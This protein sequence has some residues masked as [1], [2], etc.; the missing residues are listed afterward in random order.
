MGRLVR[1][2]ALRILR[3]F[4]SPIEVANDRLAKAAPAAILVLNHPNGI[5]DPAVI[6]TVLGRPVAFLAKSTPFGYPLKCWFMRQFGALPI[7]RA[8][9]L[10]RRGG[11]SDRDDMHRRNEETF[12]KCRALLNGGNAVA[13][14]PEG[15]THDEPMMM[16]ARTGAARIALS[17]AESSNWSVPQIIPVGIWYENSTR[18]RST[19]LVVPGK[20]VEIAA[21]RNRF[22]EAPREAV[23]ELTALLE[24]GLRAVVLEAE[25]TELL[26]SAPFIAA[27]TQPEGHK[28]DLKARQARAAELLDGYR[29]MHK[30]DPG[31]LA[32]IESAVR[33]YARMLYTLGVKDPWKLEE[34]RP[35]AWYALKRA[36][37]LLAWS[38]LALLGALMSYVPYRLAASVVRR[39]FSYNRSQAG[40]LKLVVGTMMV[41]L[42]WILEATI[43]GIVAGAP[44]GA[45]VAALA[46]LCGY[47]AIRWAE[48]A[49]KLYAVIRAGWLRRRRESL[50]SYL[51]E[52][53]QR[54][55]QEIQ[56][57][58]THL[59]TIE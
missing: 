2:F 26:K 27:W 32:S 17:A 21:F 14:F 24:E 16:P 23:H 12:A 8:V 44:W 38:P 10:G 33:Q 36:L 20:P 59:R 47:V 57:A 4:Y 41:A 13:L 18:F 54:L 51:A 43:V 49:R 7:F 3:I 11:A 15:T 30:V 58:L 46:P 5:L 42:A 53:R 34:L 48:V 50:V 37:L 6:F 45:G 31:R 25:T 52:Q 56:D 35:V 22:V 39:K 40:A 55:A 29:T 9:D 1:F 28:P 19:V